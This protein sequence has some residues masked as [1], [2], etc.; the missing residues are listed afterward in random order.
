MGLI[1]MLWQ[2]VREA[3][4]CQP[5]VHLIAEQFFLIGRLTKCIS[6]TAMEISGSCIR[7]REK[8]PHSRACSLQS[9]GSL[10]GPV[11]WTGEAQ[12]VFGS[13]LPVLF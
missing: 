7:E 3:G 9:L 1:P 4:G 5:T 8:L 6:M 11:T 12:E 10:F 13:K 2:V